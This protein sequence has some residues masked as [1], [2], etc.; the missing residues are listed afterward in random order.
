MKKIAIKLI[1]FYQA[2]S[3]NRPP[4]CLYYPSCSRYAKEAYEL[5]GFFR[6]T[7]LTVWRLM[8]CNPFSKGGFD[9]VPIPKEMAEKNNK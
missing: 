3:A 2:A 5:H 6:A 4:S 1:E 8:R 9:P 7:R